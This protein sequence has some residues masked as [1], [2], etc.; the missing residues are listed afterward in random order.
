MQRWKGKMKYLLFVKEMHIFVFA[1]QKLNL[2]YKEDWDF[3]H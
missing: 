2:M 3:E 1:T